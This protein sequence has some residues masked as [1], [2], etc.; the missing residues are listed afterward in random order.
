[1][2]DF[3]RFT[4]TQFVTGVKVVVKRC[5]VCVF[6]CNCIKKDEV[7]GY[8]NVTLETI[9]ST[10]AEKTVKKITHQVPHRIQFR[11]S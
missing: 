9:M 8:K 4:E 10:E 2:E 1:M 7:R 3:M 6:I 5:I 11:A